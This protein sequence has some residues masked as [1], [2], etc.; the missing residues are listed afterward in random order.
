[1]SRDKS[2]LFLR[3][4]RICLP[5]AWE[6]EPEYHFNAPRTQHR[7]DWA[8]P[9]RKIA[10]EVDGGR[11]AFGGGRHAGDDDKRK[12][13]LAAVMGWRVFH[14]S[15]QMLENDPYGCCEIVARALGYQVQS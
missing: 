2:P 1:M 5:D 10:V 8:W 3:C 4:W 13:N 11:Y 9:D 7:F 14:F 12:M 15:P 6:P